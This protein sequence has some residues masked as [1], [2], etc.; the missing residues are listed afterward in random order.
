MANSR[1]RTIRYK[2]R[3]TQMQ[4]YDL[5]PLGIRHSLKEGAQEWCTNAL[6]RRYRGLLKDGYDSRKAEQVLVKLIWSQHEEEVREGYPWRTR[7]PGQRW[8][9][10]SHSP[11]NQA[12]ATMAAHFSCEDCLAVVGEQ[13]ND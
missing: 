8:A 7:K 9:H 13:H 4:A 2:P 10:V 11:H 5:L 3:Y 6:L 1:T 12:A